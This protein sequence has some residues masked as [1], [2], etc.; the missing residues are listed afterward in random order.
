MLMEWLL[1]NILIS[2]RYL[3]LEP[4]TDTLIH[5]LLVV[6]SPDSKGISLINWLVQKLRA[7][8]VE[9][10]VVIDHAYYFSLLVHRDLRTVEYLVEESVSHTN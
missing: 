8:V 3:F 6:P 2:L 9:A 7:L 5:D 10:R 1:N 4:P